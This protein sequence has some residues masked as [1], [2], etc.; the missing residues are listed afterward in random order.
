MQLVSTFFVENLLLDLR[1]DFTTRIYNYIY[2]S[3][4]YFICRLL[5]GGNS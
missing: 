3:S 2:N 5:L 1:F 4:F